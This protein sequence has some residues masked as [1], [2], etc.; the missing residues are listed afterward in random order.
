MERSMRALML[1]G[2]GGL[3]ALAAGCNATV[4]GGNPLDDLGDS[5]GD[6]GPGP[7]DDGG[8]APDLS[9][10][11]L[12]ECGDHDPGCN[13]NPFG[14]PN[15]MFPLSSDGQPDPA[16]SDTGV[17]RD[18]DGYLVLGS[19]HAQFDY[20]WIANSEDWGRGT[21]S[22]MNSKTVKEAARYQTVTCFSN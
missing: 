6:G 17:N 10:G 16:E 18:P 2:C 8:E 1:V 19:T 20:V 22:K 12:N 15:K 3:L 14:P 4:R 9:L 11:P 5:A 7:S 21:V 13:G